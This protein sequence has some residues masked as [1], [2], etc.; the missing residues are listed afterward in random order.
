RFGDQC[1]EKR[2]DQVER[3]GADVVH[4]PVFE[5]HRVIQ[6]YVYTGGREEPGVGILRTH[7]SAAEKLA[8]GVAVDERA[9]KRLG[10]RCGVQTVTF[11]EREQRI[12]GADES[13]D[14]NVEIID[15]RGKTVQELRREHHTD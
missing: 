5:V 4:V 15:R 2:P 12:D 1:F 14:A 6:L 8:R 7:I 9:V 13:I 10:R 3:D 11:P